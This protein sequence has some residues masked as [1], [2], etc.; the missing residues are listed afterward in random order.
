MILPTLNDTAYGVRKKN[1]PRRAKNTGGKNYHG[2]K[3][4]RQLEN[5]TLKLIKKIIEY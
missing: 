1:S 5:N 2:I 4:S 3:Y